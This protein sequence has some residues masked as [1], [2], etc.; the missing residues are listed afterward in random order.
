MLMQTKQRKIS[1]KVC[2]CTSGKCLLG[3]MSVYVVLQNHHQTNLQLQY[4]QCPT[5]RLASHEDIV[6]T[7]VNL[8]MI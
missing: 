4:I 6:V 2:V 5:C 3:T 8:K 1:L 7:I